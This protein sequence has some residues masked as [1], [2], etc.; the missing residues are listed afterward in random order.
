L[1][2]VI[3]ALLNVSTYRILVV[4]NIIQ[5][6]SNRQPSAV[7]QK[8]SSS[9]SSIGRPSGLNRQEASLIYRTKPKLKGQ[10]KLDRKNRWA[11]RSPWRQSG[12]LG[13]YHGKDMWEML[14]LSL[15]W[16]EESNG[17]WQWW[18]WKR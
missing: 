10:R 15:E 3:V 12:W 7:I 18:W 11:V 5:L 17:R 9:I 6:G 13:S 1:L 14:V 8:I 2:N 16:R 4:F